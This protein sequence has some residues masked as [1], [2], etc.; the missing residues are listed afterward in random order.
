MKEPSNFSGA[1]LLI[2]AILVVAVVTAMT[3]LF[4]TDIFG[5]KGSGLGSEF[6][7]DLTALRVTDPALIL[8]EE[9]E[10]RFETGFEWP[11]AIS[12]GP[13]DRIYVAGDSSVHVFDSTGK[14]IDVEIDLGRPSSSMT[15][16]EDGTLYVGIGDHVEVFDASGGLRDRWESAGQEAVLTSIGTFGEHVFIAEFSTRSVLHFDTSGKQIG[17]FG[18][19]VIPS[20]YFDLAISPNGMLH[21]A[22]TGQHR[23][24]AYAFSG[25][26]ASWWGEF[27]NTEITGFCGCCNPVNFALLPENEG[28]VTSEKGLTRVKVYDA[29]GAFV[30]VVAGPEQFAQHDSLC[31]AS[32]NDCTRGGLDV[33][34]DSTGRVWV[35]DLILADVRTFSR[36]AAPKGEQISN[37]SFTPESERETHE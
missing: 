15:V 27:S 32:G 13:Q 33:A 16:A 2:G 17:S 18:D 30:G 12:I 37:A 8:Y 26:L 29:E 19:F 7:Y 35:L 21:V 11:R 20:P 6:E 24:E 9:T 1:Q 4:F 5:A 36:I 14:K 25:N 3:T 23:I 34:V 22:N 28:F 10:V 31:D